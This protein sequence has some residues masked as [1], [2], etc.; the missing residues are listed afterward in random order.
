MC[1]L[2]EPCMRR[3]ELQIDDWRLPTAKELELIHRD[4]IAN[5]AGNFSVGH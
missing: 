4:F 2:M 3:I 5:K 1:T